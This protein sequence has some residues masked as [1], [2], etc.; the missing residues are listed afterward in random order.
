MGWSN[1]GWRSDQGGWY[2]NAASGSVAFSFAAGDSG[3]DTSGL[4]THTYGGS[5]YSIGATSAATRIIAIGIA[6]RSSGATSFVAA[7]G[8][9]IGGV[10]ATFAVRIVDPGSAED[11]TE[12]WWAAVPT[13]TTATVSVTFTSAQTRSGMQ[14]YSIINPSSNAPSATGSGSETAT[15]DTVSSAS[16]LTIPSG[17]AAFGIGYSMFGGPGTP[18]GSPT[19]F[20]N[21]ALNNTIAGTQ[22]VYSMYSNVNAIAA[23]AQTLSMTLTGAGSGSTTACFAAWGP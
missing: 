3:T 14:L 8:V 23:G 2:K 12:I 13:G 15:S 22:Q 6:A 9:V 16:T 4:T 18:T 11:A 10:T 7:S 21:V 1:A 20:T 19:G 5:T 17:G